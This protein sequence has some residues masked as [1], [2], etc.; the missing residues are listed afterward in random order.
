MWQ[1]LGIQSFLSNTI[2]VQK[3]TFKFFKH[4]RYNINIIFC[5][6]SNLYTILNNHFLSLSNNFILIHNTIIQTIQKFVNA[7]TQQTSSQKNKIKNNCRTA[8]NF[9]TNNK[10]RCTYVK[11]GRRAAGKQQR[12]KY[13][14]IIAAAS[15]IAVVSDV[16]IAIEYQK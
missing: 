2:K 10:F 6:L 16:S 8:Q 11:E 3:C 15:V 1:I 4:Y 13:L 9:C 5:L 12:I 7:P 14:A